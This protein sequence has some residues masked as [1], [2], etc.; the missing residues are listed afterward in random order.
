[1]CTD[2]N[3][4]EKRFWECKACEIMG[5]KYDNSIILENLL[6]MYNKC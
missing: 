6:N 4:L 3:K 5:T 2:I 1:M